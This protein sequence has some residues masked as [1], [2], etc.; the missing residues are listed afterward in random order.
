[1]PKRSEGVSRTMLQTTSRY[2]FIPF[3]FMKITR[4]DNDYCNLLKHIVIARA[5]KQSHELEL[6]C[7]R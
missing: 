5:T 3:H 1:V 4:S 6:Q 2:N 7:Y